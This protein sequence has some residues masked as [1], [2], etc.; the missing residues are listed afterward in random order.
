MAVGK[1]LTIRD[2]S[3]CT[4]G[5]EV[6]VVGLHYPQFRTLLKAAQLGVHV[7]VMFR[8][9]SARILDNSGVRHDRG[10][11]STSKKFLCRWEFKIGAKWRQWRRTTTRRA[12]KSSR[13]A[14]LPQSGHIRS[15]YATVPRSR[16]RACAL[17][18]H[19]RM[20]G[21]RTTRAV[22]PSSRPIIWGS[23]VS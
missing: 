10:F 12:Q 11:Y 9:H 7:G 2:R 18:G 21:Q 17:S 19:R 1:M 20:A 22:R 4:G 15:A 3:L 23:H 13:H 14:S 5:S 16:V 8:R 6:P